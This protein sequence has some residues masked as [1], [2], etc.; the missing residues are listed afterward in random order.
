[1][2][3]K[4][5]IVATIG[6]ASES[7]ET[8]ENLTLAGMNVAR[9]TFSHGTHDQHADRIKRI[10]KVSEKL[11]VCVG[12]LQDLQGPKSRVGELAEP[13]QLS[14]GED[15]MLYVSGKTPPGCCAKNVP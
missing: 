2:T 14:E 1:M 8:L 11:G 6:P 15:V 10:R 13:I 4:A 5:K 7:E 3:R 9:L 12:I